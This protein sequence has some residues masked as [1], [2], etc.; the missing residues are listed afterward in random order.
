MAD[1]SIASLDMPKNAGQW[2]PIGR[3][4]TP[5]EYAGAYVFFATRGDTVPATGSI[6]NYDGGI[7][8][9]GFAAPSGG[10]DLEQ[11]FASKK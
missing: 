4:P 8:I 3:M 7:G 9:R 2:L 10:R 1:R 5:E 6:L 11:R